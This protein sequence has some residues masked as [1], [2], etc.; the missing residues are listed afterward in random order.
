[1]TLEFPNGWALHFEYVP[2]RRNPIIRLTKDGLYKAHASMSEESLQEFIEFVTE[3][4]K[5]VGE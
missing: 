3:T 1:M 2:T 5:A 4:W